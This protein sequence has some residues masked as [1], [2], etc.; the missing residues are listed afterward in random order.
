MTKIDFDA[1]LSSLNRKITDNKTKYLLVENELKKLKTF[2]SSYFRGKSHFEEDGTQNYLVFQPINR[3]F[4]VIANKLYISSWKSKGLFNETIK[5]LATSDNSVAPL[6]DYVGNKIRTKFT[7]CCLKQP[8]LQY[9]HGTIKNIY[10]VDE[11]SDS[12]SN[13]NDP[14]LKNCLFGIVTLTKNADTE[15]Y[16]YLGYGIGFDRRCIFSFPGSGFGQNVLSFGADMNFSAHINNKK[17]DKLVL[18]KRTNTRV[19]TY[20]NC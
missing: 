18:R 14:T 2:D 8:K 3:Y 15:K 16:G 10:I 13:D 6:I 11:L 17:K 12:G 19:R 7:G 4:K 5:P 20:N 9:T 1:K